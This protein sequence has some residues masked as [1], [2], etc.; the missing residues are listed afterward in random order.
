MCAVALHPVQ[1][2]VAADNGALL[3][4]AALLDT[5][6]ESTNDGDEII[7]DSI[8]EIFPQLVR[9]DRLPTHLKL[10][11]VQ[12]HRA[13]EAEALVVTGTNIISSNIYRS[14]QWPLSRSTVKSYSNKLIFLGVGWWQ[15][16]ERAGRK[17]AK[18]LHDMVHPDIPI[19]ARDQYTTDRLV[20][21]GLSAINTGCPTMWRLPAVLPPL[22]NRNECV[23]TV[24]DYN[25]NRRVDEDILKRLAHVYEQVV[26][27]PQSAG[28][29]ALLGSMSL[30]ANAVIAPRGVESLAKVLKGRD[31]IG[32]RLHAGVRAA[33]LGS[34]CLVLG[35]DNRALEI[36]RDTGFPVIERNRAVEG[37]LLGMR[38]AAG[39]VALELPTNEIEFWTKTFLSL[40]DHSKV[41]S[42]RM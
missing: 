24:T 4:S 21:M 39:G 34:A 8:K 32:T 12:R 27:W 5:S 28:D 7:V 18:A 35:V 10:T 25:P 16:Q 13:T 22:G 40:I 26:I 14:R 37:L 29:L 31:Y 15:Y 38:Q 9:L 33:Q 41:D 6:L 36:G 42:T 20:E 17:T 30:P 19:S 1:T 2:F 3:K 23:F 11:R